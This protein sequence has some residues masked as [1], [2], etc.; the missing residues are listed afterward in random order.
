M[1]GIQS[2]YWGRRAY[3]ES[4]ARTADKK[5]EWVWQ[6]SASM[7]RSALIFAGQPLGLAAKATVLGSVST[8]RTTRLSIS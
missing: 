2:V 7:G 5:R 8:G 3:Q 6:G 1:A 4:I